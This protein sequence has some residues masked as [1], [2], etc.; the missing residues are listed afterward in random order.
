MNYYGRTQMPLSV[1]GS[2]GILDNTPLQKA[3]S[4]SAMLQKALQRQADSN[5]S[6]D[7]FNTLAMC[8]FSMVWTIFFKSD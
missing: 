7:V 2:P 8:Y 4:P 3:E 6:Q 5:K 1:A